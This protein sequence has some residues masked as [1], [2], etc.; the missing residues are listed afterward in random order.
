MLFII[1]VM[2]IEKIGFYK[3]TVL[4]NDNSSRRR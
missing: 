3:F 4:I 1:E 2:G